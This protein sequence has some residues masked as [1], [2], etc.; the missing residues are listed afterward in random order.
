MTAVCYCGMGLNNEDL[1]SRYNAI[2]PNFTPEEDQVARSEDK[3]RVYIRA[4]HEKEK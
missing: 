4:K 3:I 2:E 1:T